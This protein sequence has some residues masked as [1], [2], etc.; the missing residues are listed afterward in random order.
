MAPGRAVPRPTPQGKGLQMAQRND[1]LDLKHQERSLVQD[2]QSRAG[3]LAG[4]LDASRLACKLAEQIHFANRLPAKQRVAMLSDLLYLLRDIVDGQEELP[5]DV[6][7]A[8]DDKPDGVD[9]H[10]EF[11]DQDGFLLPE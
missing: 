7:Q 3:Q 6:E 2:I 9:L 1:Y 4:N 11:Y 5:E 10:M 8:L